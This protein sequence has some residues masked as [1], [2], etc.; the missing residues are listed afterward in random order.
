MNK[1]LVDLYFAGLSNSFWL[2]DDVNGRIRWLESAHISYVHEINKLESLVF[3]HAIGL[4]RI[5][6][7]EEFKA[8]KK[9][10]DEVKA[11]PLYQALL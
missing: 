5:V 11:S 4:D 8:A 7:T 3:G 9:R 2:V 10:W 6:K 1:E